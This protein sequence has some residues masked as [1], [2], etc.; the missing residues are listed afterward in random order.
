MDAGIDAP[1][2]VDPARGRRFGRLLRAW[3]RAN[4]RDLPWRRTRDPYAILVSEVMLQQTQVDRV[5]PY[6]GAFLERF[7]TVRDLAE[8]PTAE[9]IK[10][11]AGLGYNRRAVNL[12][13]TAQ[14]IVTELG[15]RFPAEVE[16]LRALPGVGP[17]T[18]GAI[19]CFAFE[20]DVAF[21]DTNMR[22]VIHRLFVGP[23][24][25]T[26][27]VKERGLVAL[28]AAAV[29]AGRG[30]AWNQGLIEFGALQC[31]ARR[32]ACLVCPL[33]QVCRAYPEIQTRI[34]ALP[35]GARAAAEGPF[36]SSN[37]YFRGRVVAALRELPIDADAGGLELRSLGPR[38][39]DGF[40][41]ADLPWLYDVVSGL[42]RD[43]L[44]T[45][46][47]ARPAYDAGSGDEPAAI[48]V[49]AI[50]VKLP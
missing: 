2:L 45:V 15:G 19:A 13:R 24:L 31:T 30:W 28:A 35:R 12:Q 48:D 42:R 9:V 47:E 44:A 18:A 20:R 41:E 37:R 43:G 14:H 10:A 25:P 38:V 32:P 39:R 36:T 50:R 4:A 26:P 8:A 7:S 6:Y 17:Y 27:L 22:R 46:A 40:G 23:E 34:A 49:G 5:V 11:W 29:P 1:S 33:R 21:L 3:Y 16:A